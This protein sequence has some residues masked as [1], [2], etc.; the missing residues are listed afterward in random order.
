MGDP[1]IPL[2]SRAILLDTFLGLLQRFLRKNGTWLHAL[3]TCS[4]R[5]HCP[6]HSLHSLG[7]IPAQS[8]DPVSVLETSQVRQIQG[9][10]EDEGG[11]VFLCL[12]ELAAGCCSLCCSLWECCYLRRC[13]AVV[14][15]LHS[16][17]IHG[18]IPAPPHL[19]DALQLLPPVPRLPARSPGLGPIALPGFIGNGN[20]LPPPAAPRDAGCALDLAP[21]TGW[22]RDSRLEERCLQPSQSSVTAPSATNHPGNRDQGEF[23]PHIPNPNTA[24]ATVPSRASTG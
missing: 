17:L 21:C 12:P 7:P 24:H 16:H 3:T 6:S 10:H 13:A 23:P 15:L 11:C 9:Q 22:K 2:H 14:A 19:P 8:P 5:Q 1:H 18:S 4:I 20:A